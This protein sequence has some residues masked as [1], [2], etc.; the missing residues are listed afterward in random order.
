MPKQT[1]KRT[2]TYARNRRLV[3]RRGN[4]LNIEADGFYLF[5]LVMVVFLGLLWIKLAQPLL[6]FG[7]PFGGIPAGTIVGLVLIAVFEKNP[8]DRRIWYAVL[9]VVA[10]IG[11]FVPAGIVV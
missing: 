9:M 3:S 7:V 1:T 2:R 11:Y 10:I 8:L 6:W 5:K 4:I